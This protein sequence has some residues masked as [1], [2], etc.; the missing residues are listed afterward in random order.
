[1]IITRNDKA[2]DFFQNK[3]SLSYLYSAKV[4]RADLLLQFQKEFEVNSTVKPF[5]G[6]GLDFNFHF[7]GGY[8]GMTDKA[9]FLIGVDGL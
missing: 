4:Q 6:F 9:F 5:Y 1:M 8:K 2:I 3:S 7:V